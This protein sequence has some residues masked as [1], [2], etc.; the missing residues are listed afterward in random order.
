MWR[1]I[2]AGL[3]MLVAAPAAAQT[4]P[5]PIASAILEIDALF[6]QFQREVPTPGLV[7]GIVANGRL[8][9]VRGFGGQDVTGARP[10]DADTIF[11]IASMTKAFTALSILTLR[12]AGKLDLDDPAEKYVPEMRGW[13]YPTSDSPRIRIRDLLNH[14]A[15]F[16][17][18]DPWGDRQTSLPEAEFTAMLKA[19]VPFSR[20]PRM[21]HEYSNFGYALLGRIVANVSGMP[22]RTY[23]ERTILK[24]LGMRASGY[25][26]DELDQGRRAI[27]YRHEDGE[28]RV[29]PTM[30]HGAFGAMGGLSVS[31]ND[32]AKWIAFLLSAWPPRDGAETGP[33]RRS[34]VREMATGSNFVLL[35][36]TG[37]GAEACPQAF[38][39]AMGLR[40]VQDCALGFT[41]SHGGG[42]PGYGSHILMLPD[43]GIGIF[44]F[45]NRTYTGGSSVAWKAAGLLVKAGLLPV[46]GVAVT[47]RVAAAHETALAIYE[48]G[49][50]APFAGR[51]AMNFV[52]DRSTEGWRSDLAKLRA[53][54]GACA[55]KEPVVAESQ[56]AGRFRWQCEKGTIEGQVLLA[57]TTPPTIQALRLMPKPAP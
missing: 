48:A 25:E 55:G 22:Y 50:I 19:G 53:Q 33:V 4:A 49:D 18:D 39:Y 28:W 6:E 27:G 52:M 44:V 56:L 17:T 10:V 11:R 40:L 51:L 36:G 1:A 5:T 20:T 7:Y 42:Y 15:G 13:G 32:Y 54:L 14:V 9:H 34:T 29:E 2:M 26:V 57:P 24:P 12:D 8:V 16:V 23:V 45:T 46:R 30:H 37:I 43:R 41:L 3:A 21:A 31:A 35:R 47:P 38:A